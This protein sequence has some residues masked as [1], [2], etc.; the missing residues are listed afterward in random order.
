MG[1]GWHVVET[2]SPEHSSLV[3]SRGQRAEWQPLGSIAR[4][5]GVDP[6]PFVNQVR[7]SG[8]HVDIFVPSGRGEKRVIAAPTKGPDGAVHAVSI[9]IGDP[10]EDLAGDPQPIL[11]GIAFDTSTYV[12]THT[13]QCRELTVA[14]PTDSAVITSDLGVL[15]Q[16]VFAF[17]SAAELADHCLSP[18]LRPR[19][20]GTL[21]VKHDD[22]RLLSVH[23]VSS[24]DPTSGCLRAIAHDIT[25]FEPVALTP[26]VLQNIPQMTSGSSATL[27]IG[28]P[29]EGYPAPALA[30]WVTPRPELLYNPSCPNSVHPDDVEQLSLVRQQLIDEP[31]VG[32]QTVRLRI[33]GRD[34]WVACTL[35]CTRWPADTIASAVLLCQLIID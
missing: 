28:V 2:L 6:A 23:A 31:G 11:G 7:A 14:V 32:F 10:G 34:G 4:H 1:S 9:W 27:M 8:E 35:R 18:A 13:S 5:T 22:G 12:I 29:D 17:D 25:A 33:Y 26:E 20:Q 15:L 19:F 16:R 30:Y 24:F 21:G 3:W